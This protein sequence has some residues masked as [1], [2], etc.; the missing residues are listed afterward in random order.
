MIDGNIIWDDG[1]TRPCKTPLVDLL[2]RV[3]LLRR[4]LFLKASAY[5]EGG[6]RFKCEDLYFTNYL[7]SGGPVS[8][9][10]GPGQFFYPFSGKIKGMHIHRAD[11]SASVSTSFWSNK[12]RGLHITSCPYVQCFPPLSSKKGISIMLICSCFQMKCVV[13]VYQGWTEFGFQCQVIP[14]LFYIETFLFPIRNFA[15][16]TI[17]T[18]D[19]GRGCR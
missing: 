9:V 6:G 15:V 5:A 2:V 17:F 16:K 4:L 8:C 14:E 1:T 12:K 7:L 13:Y 10:A 11:I 3:K 19:P 18:C